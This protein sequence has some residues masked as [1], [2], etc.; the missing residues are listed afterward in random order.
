MKTA[1]LLFVCFFLTLFSCDDFLNQEPDQQISIDEQLSTKTGILEALNGIYRDIEATQSSITLLYADLQGGN[2]TFTPSNSNKTIAVPTVFENSY[3]FNDFEQFSDYESYY[4]EFYD[5]INQTNIILDRFDTYTFL[6]D[7]DK[8]Q[9]QAELLVCRAFAHY[10]VSLLYSQNY[11]FTADASHLGIVYNITSLSIGEDFPIRKTMKETYD[12]LKK[13]LDDALSL[14]TENNFFTAPKYALFNK[15]TTKALY[16]KIALQMND[17]QQ[18][19]AYANEVITT[20]GI[21]LT[22]KENYI[23]EWEKEEDPIS[24]IVLEFSA[25]RNSDNSVSSSISQYFKYE[26]DINYGRYVASGDLLDLYETNDIRGDLFINENLPTIVTGVEVNLPYYFTK[27]FQNDAGTSYIRL[28]ELYLIRAEANAR[29]N[30]ENA[31]LIDLNSIRERAGLSTLNTTTNIL[32]EIFLE[33]RRELAFESQLFFDLARYKKDVTRD[34]GC[35]A[36]T[37]NLSYPSNF[38]VLPIPDSSIDLNENIKQNE[39]Y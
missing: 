11:G 37:C 29:T 30:Q 1:K 12:L 21:I 20:S 9:L 34:K 38:F 16:A 6:S 26:S 15:T 32:D 2:I 3:S 18:A 25:P 8:N 17:W 39:G 31:A 24:E 35:L 36:T 14:F 28:S 4:Q 23:S 10:Q 27:K 7:E 33:R 19:F 13:D 5:I 22:S